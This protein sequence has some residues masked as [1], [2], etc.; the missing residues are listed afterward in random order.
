MD[1][2]RKPQD[3]PSRR[4]PWFWLGLVCW[5]G[6]GYLLFNSTPDEAG[7]I[8]ITIFFLLIATGLFASLMWLRNKLLRQPPPA[9]LLAVLLIAA[10]TTGALALNTIEIQAGEIFLLVVFGAMLCI[11]WLKVRKSS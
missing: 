9:S 7:P 10:L 2:S 3:K 4:R 1:Q 5:L 11:Y 8:G 6:F